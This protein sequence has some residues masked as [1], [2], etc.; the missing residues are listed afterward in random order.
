MLYSSIYLYNDTAGATLNIQSS[1][2]SVTFSYPCDDFSICVPYVVCLLPGEYLFELWGAEGGGVPDFSGCSKITG[3]LGGYSAGKIHLDKSTTFYLFIGAHSLDYTSPWKDHFK[4]AYN[5]GG[6]AYNSPGGGGST[7][8]RL[9][10]NG[11]ISNN[12]SLYSRIIVSGGGGGSDCNNMGGGGGGI[13]GGSTNYSGGG[14]QDT[15]GYGYPNGSFWLGGSSETSN[16]AAGGGGYYGGGL[17]TSKN[18]GGGGGSSYISGHEKCKSISKNGEITSSPIHYSHLKFTESIMIQGGE[19]KES[20]YSGLDTS[21]KGHG[22][23]RITV[24]SFEYPKSLHYTNYDEKLHLIYNA[25]FIH[26]IY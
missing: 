12:D 20:P 22:M 7:D 8:I 5:G 10:Y 23:A 21:R 9:T 3:G 24:L 4:I 1:P 19:E 13:E 2:S 14:K 15:G 6:Y 18:S 16:A 11:D 17:G 25:I 26:N